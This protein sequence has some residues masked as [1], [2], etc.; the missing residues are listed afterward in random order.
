MASGD[1]LDRS[2]SANAD[3]SV[4]R[5]PERTLT[6]S[7]STSSEDDLLLVQKKQTL[8]V[9]RVQLVRGLSQESATPSRHGA[10][11]TSTPRNPNAVLRLYP[12]VD[13]YPVAIGLWM[14]CTTS[15]LLCFQWEMREHKNGSRGKSPN[16]SPTDP[17]I[18]KGRWESSPLGESR[19]FASCSRSHFRE[20]RSTSHTIFK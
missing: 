4:E 19:R 3:P 1:T 20:V 6:C 13:E 10:T 7:A 14:K 8:I 11:P 17:F 9:D 15:N 16:V 5:G 18:R 12:R 2:L